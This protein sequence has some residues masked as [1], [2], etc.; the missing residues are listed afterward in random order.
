MNEAAVSSETGGAAHQIGNRIQVGDTT[1]ADT[2]IGFRSSEVVT[3][4]NID[5]IIPNADFV[6]GKVT[7]W[8]QENRRMH[9]PVVVVVRYEAH[10]DEVSELLFDVARHE[11]G[12]LA[13]PEPFPLFEPFG[14]SA[15]PFRL[16]Y[17]TETF[18]DQPAVLQSRLN[19]E[20]LLR[21][22]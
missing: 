11:E 18:T 2:Q 21:L 1:G 9:F 4:D 15:L 16:R 19:R 3:N 7:N 20:I 12:T 10:P 13:E 6:P 17:W 14:D 8:T 5:L 22:R